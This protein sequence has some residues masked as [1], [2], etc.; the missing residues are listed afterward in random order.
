MLI[1]IYKNLSQNIYLKLFTILF[2]SFFLIQC[3]HELSVKSEKDPIEYV[4]PFIGTAAYGHTFPG[5]AQPFGMVQLSPATGA[6]RYKGYSYSSVPHG[7]D[8][9]TIIGFTHT[10]VSGTGIGH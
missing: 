4:N 5:A 2:V 10:N 6:V 8:S 3:S 9:D 7:R 1:V